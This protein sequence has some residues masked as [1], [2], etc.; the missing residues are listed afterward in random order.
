M[1]QQA[2]DYLA[3]KAKTHSSES[4]AKLLGKF[5]ETKSIDEQAWNEKIKFWNDILTKGF[6]MCNKVTV[7]VP[8]IQYLLTLKRKDANQ[9]PQGWATIIVTMYT[10]SNFF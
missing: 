5:K 7:D 9:M 8:F 6:Q 4:F 2:Q 1:Q 10:M 3:E